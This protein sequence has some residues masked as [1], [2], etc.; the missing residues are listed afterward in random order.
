MSWLWDLL[1]AGRSAASVATPQQALGGQ[2]TPPPRHRPA[3]AAGRAPTKDPREARDYLPHAGGAGQSPGKTPGVF[4]EKTSRYDDALSSE[5]TDSFRNAD[6]SITRRLHAGP[7]NFKGAD[8]HWHAINTDLVRL[9]DGRLAM[10]ANSLRVSLAGRAADVHGGGGTGATPDLVTMALPG[11]PTL[12]YGLDGAASVDPVVSGAT[13]TYPAIL[14]DTDLQLMTFDSGVM[15]TLVLTS[16][17]APSTWVFPLRLN[18]LTPRS[19]PDGSIGLYDGNGTLAARFPHGGMEDSKVD[20][21]SGAGARSAAVTFS[22][23]TIHGGPALRVSA[24]P[25]WLHDPARVFPVKVDPTTADG[26]T[27]DVYVDNDPTTTAANQD[28]NDLAIGTFDGGT[29]KSRAFV[30]FSDFTLIVPG[31]HVTAAQLQLYMTWSSSCTV[32]RPFY[33]SP[34]TQSWTVAGLSTSVWPGPTIGSSIGSLTPTNTSPACTNTAGNRSVGEYVYVPITTL[35]PL[36]NW[37]SG[38]QPNYGLALTASETDSS[39]WKRFTSANYSGGAYKPQLNITYTPNSV[40]TVTSQFPPDNYSSPTLTPELLASATDPD[41]WPKPMT[42][43][44]SIS[45]VTNYPTVTPVV[46]SAWLSTPDWVVP[47]GKLVWSHT[48]SWNV[49]ASDQAASFVSPTRF[50]STPP[51]QPLVLSGLSQNQ[52]Q[53]GFDQGIG[54]YTTSVTD[55][56]VATMGPSLQI[57]RSYNS[58][59]PRTSG[60]FGAGWSSVADAKAVE[61]LDA[62]G[63]V[64]TVTVTYP[65]GQQVAFGRNTD[66][67]FNPGLGRF[68]TF[69]ATTTP[70]GYSLVDKNDTVFTFAQA[71]GGGVYGL[72]SIADANGR[73]ESFT[74]NTSNQLITITSASG[75]ALQLTWG[76]SAGAVFPHVSTV[77][78]DPVTVGQPTTA[79]TWTYTYTGDALAS[80][81]PPTSATACHGYSYVAGSPY[82]SAVLD[83]GPLSYWRLADAIGATS[84]FDS[85]LENNVPGH[86]QASYSGATLGSPGGLPGSGAGAASFNGTSSYLEL[87]A[88]LVS[89]ASF[90]TISMWFKTT[91]AGV[92]FSYQTDPITG[93]T[94]SNS[95]TP[96]LYVGTDGYLHGEFWYSAGASP[97]TSPARVDDGA[98]HHVVLSGGG[99]S[100]KMYVDNVSRSAAGQ[101]SQVANATAHEYIGAGFI[102]GA[103]PNEAHQSGTSSTGY[104]QYFTGSISDVAF[105]STA[106]TDAQVASMYAAGTHTA[107]L[108]SQITRPSGKVFAQVGYDAVSGRVTQ[109]TDDAG[110]V[111]VV[112]APTTSVSYLA[113]QSAVIGSST[114]GV[115]GSSP[116]DYLPLNDTPN[117][118]SQVRDVLDVPGDGYY[119]N[120]SLGVPGPYADATAASFNGTSSYLKPNITM[121]ASG[122]VSVEFFFKTTVKNQVLFSYSS[123]PVVLATTPGNYTPALYVGSDGRLMGVFWNS[124]QVSSPASVADG[125]WHLATLATSGTGV[126]LYLDGAPVG[127]TATGTVAVTGQANMYLG[128]GFI[129]GIWPNESHYSTTSNTGYASFFSGT[130]AHFS[131]YLKQLS[132]TDAATHWETYKDSAG[133]TPPVETVVV[134]D[135]GGAATSYAYDLRHG[136]RLLSQTMNDPTSMIG[137]NPPFA[138]PQPITTNYGYDVNGFQNAVWDPNGIF[139][140]TSHDVRGNVSSTMTCQDQ[141]NQICSTTYFTYFPDA[142]TA[143]LAPGPRN[144]LMLTIRDGRSSSSTDTTYLTS[145]GYDSAGNRT[146]VTTP[147]VAGY[148]SGRTAATVFTDGSATYPAVDTGNTPAGLPVT[149]T[150]PG[151]AVT[152]LQYFHNGDVAKMTSPSGLQTTFGY[153]NLGRVTSRTVVSDSYPAGL[154]TSYTY[155]GVGEM[156]T[157]TDPAVL[158]RVTGATHTAL[159]TTT[160]DFDGNITAQ[161]VADTTGGDLTRATAATYDAH[162]RVATSTDAAGNITHYTYDTEGNRTS[163]TDASGTEV[164][165][166]YD[167]SGH[168][169][170]ATLKGFTG[171]PNNPSPATNLVLAKRYYDADGRLLTTL[172]SM[173]NLINYWYYDNGLLGQTYVVPHDNVANQVTE[174]DRY[175]A[176][177]NLTYRDNNNTTTVTNYTVDAAGRTT[178]ATV[179]P[180]GVKRSTS[181]QYDGDDHILSTKVYDASGAFSTTDATYNTAGQL[182]SRTVYND[183][184]TH[185]NGWWQ[186]NETSGV[187]AADSSGL[188]Q[189]GTLSTGVAWS[190]GG[191]SFNGSNGVIATAGPVLNTSQSYSVSAWVNLASTSTYYTAVSQGGNAAASFYLQYSTALRSWTFVSPSSDST[192]VSSYPAAHATTTPTLNTWTHLVGVFDAGTGGM[193]L[194]VNGA[195]AGTGTNTTPWNSTGPLTIGGVRLVNASTNNIFNGQVAN[196]QIYQRAVSAAD[197]STLYAAGNGRTGGALSTSRLTTSFVSDQRGLTTAATD[198]NGATTAYVNDEAGR[199]VVA[200][201]PTVNTEVAG[202]TPVPTHPVSMIGYDTFGEKVETSDPNGNVVTTAFD[203]D[204]RVTS[205]TLPNY[206]PPGSATAITA[207]ASRAYNSIGQ[208]VSDTDPLLHQSTY[209]YDQLGNLA[210]ATAPNLGVTKFTYDTNGERLSTTDPTGAQT[211]ATYDGLGRIATSTQVVRQPTAA[212]YTTRYAYLDTVGTAS[213]PGFLASVTSP[214]GVVTSYTHDN[215]GETTSVKDGAANTTTYTYDFAGRVVRTTMPDGSAATTTYDRAGRAVG[216]A[217]LSAAGVTLASTSL[218]LDNNGNPQAVTDPRGNTSTF[219]YDATNLLTTEVQPVAAGTSITTSFGYDSA[220]NR[221]RYTDGRANNVITT[222]NTWNLPESRILPATATYTSAATSTYTTAY[223]ANGHVASQSLPGGVSISNT[224]DAMGNLAGQSGT[225]AE[226]ATVARSF[227]YDSVGQLTSVSAGA[228]SDT[229]TYDDRGLLLSTAGPSGASTFTYNGDAQMS[230]RTDAAGTSTYTYDTAGRLSTVA[231]ASTGTTL[232]LAY[233]SLSQP[234]SI[235]YGTGGDVRSFTY[236]LTHR[237]ASDTLATSTGATIASIGY[238]YDA[239]G[240]LTS[241]NTT[242]FAGAANNI[243]TY[244]QANRLLSWNN[245]TTTIGYGYDGSGNRTQAGSQTFTYD[246]RDQLISGGGSTYAYTARGTLASTTTGVVTTP[247]TDD[248]FGQAISQGGQTYT[249]DGLGRMLTATGGLTLFYS[250][251]GNTPASDGMSSYSRGPSGAV[252]GE[253]TAGVGRLLW[254]DQHTDIV[255]QFTSSGT[256]LAGSATYDPLGSVLSAATFAGNLGYQ[257]AFTDHTSGR[258]NMAARWYN[259]ATGQFDNRDSVSVSPAPNSNSANP[260]AYVGDNPLGDVDPSG[261]CGWFSICGVVHAVN[262]VTDKAVSVYHTATKVATDF[263]QDPIGTLSHGLDNLNKGL[264]WLVDQGKHLVS[265]GI[266]KVADGYHAATKIVETVKN[267]TVEAAKHTVK[268]IAQHKAQ[269]VGILVGAAVGVGC[270]LA[271]G[272]TGVGAVACGYLAGYAGSLASSLVAGKSVG[273]AMM[274]GTIGGLTGA[275]GGAIG[276][277]LG[278]KVTQALLGKAASG[279]LSRIGAGTLDGIATGGAAG[280]GAGAV[281]SALDYGMTCSAK[282]N[283]SW[284][285]LASSMTFGAIQGAVVGAVFGGALGALAG[286][287]GAGKPKPSVAPGEDPAGAAAPPS[288]TQP[289]AP[290][291]SP[292]EPANAHEPGSDPA[293]VSAHEPGQAPE[294]QEPPAG[295]SCSL[296]S[297]DPDTK[298]LMADGTT[299][300]IKDIRLD[301]K[302]VATDPVTGATI[303]KPVVALHDNQDTDLADVTITITASTAKTTTALTSKV[304][305]LMGAAAMSV[306]AVAGTVVLHTTDH[307]PF[308]DQTTHS[309]VEAA[310][311]R[312]GDQLTTFNGATATVAAVHRHTSRHDMRDLTVADIHTYYVIAGTTPVLVHNC[313][314]S[315]IYKSEGLSPNELEGAAIQARDRF[316]SE[317]SALSSKRRPNVAIGGYNTETGEFAAAASS[318]A[319]CAELCVINMLGGD[320]SKVVRTVPVLLRPSNLLAPRPVCLACEVQFGRD[321]VAPETTFESDILRLFD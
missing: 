86:A 33:V 275:V 18:G 14:P 261:H 62:T 320:A 272:F 11:G 138:G 52:S 36:N 140:K 214:Q 244:D 249:Y 113:L 208:V 254:T 142:T 41:N 70:P 225:G 241:K 131:L 176:A 189:T 95:Y 13:A 305:A 114:T 276:G 280:A 271:V 264:D 123:D 301:D 285:Q 158:D 300:A 116:T 168:M 263:V 73:T 148:P 170:T 220:G 273:Q 296:H 198:P 290:T 209:T 21:R 250:G 145:F 115:A 192:A 133:G 229:F 316:A 313:N 310:H 282:H 164:D 238:G 160:Y 34:V 1:R 110:G 56:S 135:P 191:A 234:A 127:S 281:A 307:H 193:S 195:L 51:P 150:T 218:T 221:T 165:Y 207:K 147:P 247:T 68:A 284:S 15:E 175:D 308:Y 299:K 248:A 101:I 45:D 152:R 53:H 186:L 256:S 283:C 46:S 291:K 38:A 159:S 121:P 108:L 235:T 149:E 223:D 253:K 32:Y 211:Q 303:D 162:N 40:P 226:A 31:F 64:Q 311:L 187:L 88:N 136:G 144:D 217:Q 216:A 81:C 55:A 103:W 67:S 321:N 59:D 61:N 317:M 257:S 2:G 137:Y 49:T 173:N 92:L 153:D 104:A 129:G 210:S 260:F 4:D 7:V 177:G 74:Y 251:L 154:T 255:G 304:A 319:G 157:E 181:F 212:A 266:H 10:A 190:G 6:G 215:T 112:D 206:T 156:R 262:S 27:G 182:T 166:T 205:T 30:A 312:V 85:V 278:G 117:Q 289:G 37:V 243:Y 252:I 71:E 26:T 237:L 23:I 99:T 80:V 197:V 155:D 22:I 90:N 16:A 297:F 169:L 236:D 203:A 126:T 227:G 66:G 9:A 98:W 87:P 199:L 94:T 298:V 179:D 84:P 274:E 128:A 232:A 143:H 293:P 188:Q 3:G 28:G 224:Y 295:P 130:M 230:S 60:A 47:S 231:D 277:A 196:V 174:T 100:Q 134:H 171:D 72:T 109:V 82:P 105:Y 302:V 83:A 17:D 242:G 119:S 132:A 287:L 75:R 35:T 309:F 245:G 118:M 163:Q 50:L 201:A 184:A 139:T 167:A 239:S 267:K 172:D 57:E 24:D 91:T 97:M 25:A 76:T 314:T 58:R 77:A 246:A 102:G 240:N 39:G 106:L 78:T 315:G 194:Y 12:G 69:S 233:N 125:Q 8:G 93:A 202:G 279:L 258:V 54:N 265:Q 111:W 120:V 183:A 270:G 286:G 42:Y 43:Q 5:T 20:P 269:V 146:S 292:S 107:S 122:A 180:N 222:Y 19:L 65:Q 294:A 178:L 161:S 219:V 200:T 306:A 318:S 185:P 213:G 151:G 29:T 48:Y 228:S 79:L 44:F 63:T 288:E 124:A 268:W 204:A 89:Q 141:V 96:S 259:P